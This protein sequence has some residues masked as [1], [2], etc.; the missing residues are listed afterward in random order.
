M[1]YNFFKFS[2]LTVTAAL[3]LGLMVSGCG[4]DGGKTTVYPFNPAPVPSP[5]PSP[6]AETG[7]LKLEFDV[8]LDKAIVPVRVKRYHFVIKDAEGTPADYNVTVDGTEYP[9]S[10]FDIDKANE[11]VI[12]GI[13]AGEGS[14][15]VGYTDEEGNVLAKDVETF[16]VE[17]GEEAAAETDYHEAVGI[18]AE[19]DGHE[20]AVEIGID[21]EVTPTFYVFYSELDSEEFKEEVPA[22]KLYVDVD[23]TYQPDFYDNTIIELPSPGTVKGISEGMTNL[24]LIYATDAYDEALSPAE[25]YEAGAVICSNNND[26]TLAEIHP[27]LQITVTGDEGGD[28]GDEGGDEGGDQGGDEGGDQGG[29]EGGDEGGEG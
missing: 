23:G 5:T 24:L 15:E 26:A 7:S 14:V 9:A 19:Y 28:G 25:N 27:W 1:T 13:E 4:D 20:D 18:I 21:E 17:A 11:V 16:T 22:D 10:G 6:V 29:D 8:L 2:T 3:G 12:D